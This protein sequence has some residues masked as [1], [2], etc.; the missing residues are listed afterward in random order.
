VEGE[1]LVPAKVGPTVQGNMGVGSKGNVSGEY[2]YGEGGGE[3][4]EAYGQETG[5]GNNISNVSKEIYLIKNN[6]KKRRRNKKIKIN[7]TKNKDILMF[8]IMTVGLL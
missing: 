4:M 2:P 6:I 5:K 8:C 3:G 1:A 7:K